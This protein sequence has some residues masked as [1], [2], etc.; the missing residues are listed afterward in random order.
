MA[1]YSRAKLFL[2]GSHT[3]V[4]IGEDGPS[5]MGLEDIAM[6]R[7]LFGSIVLCPADAVSSE[8]LTAIGANYDG[9]SY[10]RT[11]RGKTPIVYDNTE[12]FHL[13]GSKVLKQSRHDHATIV[14]T[15]Y[16][17]SE[18]LKA[19]E[20]LEDQESVSVRVIDCYSLKPVDGETLQKA[21]EE[22][23]IIITVED[24][25][26]EGGLGE[27][28]SSVVSGHALVHSLAVTRMPHSGS[29]ENLLHEQG[30][31]SYGIIHKFH[32]LLGRVPQ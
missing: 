27:I 32:E 12:E 5:Q 31:D 8:K 20:E 7:S 21:A 10:L 11:I 1:S 24:H 18:A 29:A 19:A 2:S 30:I 25:Y 6:M 13:G 3:G 22:T 15:G 14:A 23:K 16:P 4:S 28:V 9:I 26:P 17:V